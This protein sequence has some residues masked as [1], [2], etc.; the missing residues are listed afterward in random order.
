MK[1][2][3]P[4]PARRGFLAGLPVIRKARLFNCPGWPRPMVSHRVVPT[5]NR[6]NGTGKNNLWQATDSASGFV[7]RRYNVKVRGRNERFLTRQEAERYAAKVVKL[8]GKA[9]CRK[10]RVKVNRYTRRVKR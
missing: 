5:K 10:A 1:T 6:Y 4:Y 8:V 2:R 7:P 9:K 3:V